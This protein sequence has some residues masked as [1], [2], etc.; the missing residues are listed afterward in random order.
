MMVCGFSMGVAMR[1][2]RWKASTIGAQP[3]QDLNNVISLGE[4]GTPL[5]KSRALA[6]SLGL[7]HLYLKAE[8][9]GPTGSFKDRQATVA[10]SVLREMGIDELVVASTGNVAISY[11]AYG[12][13]AGIKVW[14][15][16]PSLAP[17]DKMREA[18][19]YGA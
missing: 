12:A 17:G 16:F 13:R 18:A 15:F 10:L 8:R 7:R 3:L 1:W 19:I 5:I 9:Q 4:G 2:P 14:A 6:A 11:A